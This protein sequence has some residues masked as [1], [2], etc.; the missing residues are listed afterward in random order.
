MFSIFI[1]L[2]LFIE[3]K[4]NYKEKIAADVKVI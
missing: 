1:N 4:T 3:D 2:E